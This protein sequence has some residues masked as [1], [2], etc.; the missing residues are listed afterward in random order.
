MRLY[1]APPPCNNGWLNVASKFVCPIAGES[2]LD[3]VAGS[4][5]NVVAFVVRVVAE[6]R[7]CV[8]SAVVLV[9][10]DRERCPGPVRRSAANKLPTVR[11][12]PVLRPA[13]L[14]PEHA[15]VELG[16]EFAERRFRAG[17]LE[18]RA[19]REAGHRFGERRIVGRR[20]G[21]RADE[22]AR[23]R[24]RRGRS[25]SAAELPHHLAVAERDLHDFLS[26]R[27]QIS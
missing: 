3:D 16:V 19:D 6:R 9:M 12:R 11:R 13:V 4:R 21:D 24:F 5:R 8:P 26:G 25:D 20:D 10:P 7:T 18:R 17:A 14:F 23:D 1:C 22:R 15:G 2:W 27:S